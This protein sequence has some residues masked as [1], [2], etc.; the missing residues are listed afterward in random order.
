M[1]DIY[2]SVTPR[3]AVFPL[4]YEYQLECC[5]Q[6]SNISEKCMHMFYI[7]IYNGMLY[8][9]IYI[10]FCLAV[11]QKRRHVLLDNHS[12]IIC[13]P[14]PPPPLYRYC[15][16]LVV[17]CWTLCPRCPICPLWSVS[18]RSRAWQRV[19]NPR[20]PTHS[21]LLLIRYVLEHKNYSHMNYQLL[22]IMIIF[23]LLFMLGNVFSI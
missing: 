10:Y 19:F 20:D 5:A 14:P 18:S 22:S 11:H 13:A 12:V 23:I 1:F 6:L 15:C 7:I 8:L 16:P 17:T 21:W 9:P 2:V 4:Y 3:D